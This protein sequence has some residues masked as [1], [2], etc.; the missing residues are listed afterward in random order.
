MD[1]PIVSK[2][3]P[4]NPKHTKVSP[5]KEDTLRLSHKIMAISYDYDKE[6]YDLYE[7]HNEYGEIEV[8]TLGHSKYDNSWNV[9]PND[10][11]LVC[12]KDSGNDVTLTVN[13]TEVTFDY[14][15]LQMLHLALW[16]YYKAQKI[17]CKVDIFKMEKES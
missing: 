17:K 3:K 1:W 10:D 14:S 13:G 15:E 6:L 4:V 16:K 2:K 5:L 11:P 12:L 8:L 9:N 7:A